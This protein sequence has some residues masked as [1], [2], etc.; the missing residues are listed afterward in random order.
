MVLFSI[1][2]EKEDF[3]VKSRVKTADTAD[4]PT[5]VKKAGSTAVDSR[6]IRIF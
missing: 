2:E 3:K 4:N 5:N 1:S 6:R